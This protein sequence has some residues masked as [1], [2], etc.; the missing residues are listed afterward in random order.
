MNGTAVDLVPT[1]NSSFTGLSGTMALLDVGAN[2]ILAPQQ[3]VIELFSHIP[4]SR[5]IAEGQWAV[6]CD[7]R[8][9]MTFAFGPGA[10]RVIELQPSEWMYAQVAGSSMCLAWPVVAP[11]NSDADWQLGTPFLRKVY[12]VFGYGIEGVQG[13]VVGFLPLPNLGNS[14]RTSA[15]GTTTTTLGTTRAVTD[16]TPV[17][18]QALSQVTSL[19][20]ATVQTVLPNVLLPDPSYTTPAYY[21]NTS[22]GIPTSGAIQTNGL[23][24]ASVY[25]VVQ[26]PIITSVV[27]TS[28]ISTAA[29]SVRPSVGSNASSS[30]ADITVR[31][32]IF[33]VCVVAIFSL[34]LSNH[35]L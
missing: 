15:N 32:C 28:A 24:N 3:D 21:F 17:S 5:Q 26:V 1:W 16:P 30:N 23:A 12:T 10:G 25:S 35:K 29:H 2:G 8:Q 9:T 7:S 11:P 20:T 34:V 33:Y 31:P 13:P 22:A 6:P 27:Q 4:D 14:T 18:V 19:V